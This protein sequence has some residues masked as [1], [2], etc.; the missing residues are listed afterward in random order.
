MQ[1][2]LL[3]PALSRDLFVFLRR[4]QL[5]LVS[6]A[7]FVSKEDLE[8]LNLTPLPKGWGY[9]CVPPY[10]VYT[11]LGNPGLCAY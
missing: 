3:M 5:R 2:S 7:D 11:M 8:F 4:F 1:I 9:R 10:P 6:W